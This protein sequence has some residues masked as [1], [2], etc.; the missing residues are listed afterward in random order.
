[1]AKLGRPGVK[2]TRTWVWGGLRGTCS[3]LGVFAGLGEVCGGASS[4]GGGCARRDIAGKRCS[5][6]A[7][8]YGLQ[9]LAPKG[10]GRCHGC[11]PRLGTGGDMTQMCRRRGRAAGRWQHSGGGAA[12]VP[13]PLDPVIRHVEFLR[14]CYG[15]QDG[16]RAT[17]GEKSRRRNDSPAVMREHDSGDVEA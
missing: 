2:S 5:T 13:W 1:M 6:G 12:G 3:P 10:P 4:C 11:S 14:R 15:G 17:G 16:P 9:D 8:G 7:R